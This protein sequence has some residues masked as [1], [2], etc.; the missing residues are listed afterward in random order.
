MISDEQLDEYRVAGTQVR[1]V[2]DEM[3]MN[4]VVGIVVAW[5]DDSVMIRKPSRRV[6]KL[7][8]AYVYQPADA[9]RVSPTEP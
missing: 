3:E 5:D 9:V 4:D 1:V 6:V 8:R 7:S 2:R